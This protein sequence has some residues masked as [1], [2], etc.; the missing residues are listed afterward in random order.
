MRNTD[1]IYPDNNS[2]SRNRTGTVDMRGYMSWLRQ[3][4]YVFAGDY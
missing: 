4:G 3:H 2:G 1:T